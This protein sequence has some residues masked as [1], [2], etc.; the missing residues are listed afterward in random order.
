MRKFCLC[1]GLEEEE[2]TFFAGFFLF[3]VSI[4]RY[5]LLDKSAA[6]EWHLLRTAFEGLS[7]SLR[8]VF[9]ID[10]ITAPP[11]HVHLTG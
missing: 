5:V 6:L 10:A 1:F 11:P 8:P 9:T 7:P 4:S 2:G 3:K